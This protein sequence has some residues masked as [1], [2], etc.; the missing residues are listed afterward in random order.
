MK[1]PERKCVTLVLH[2]ISLACLSRAP[3]PVP[4]A[5]RITLEELNNCRVTR[6]H[7]EKWLDQ[8]HL[9]RLLPGLFVR[10]GAQL[11]LD[12]VCM[13]ACVCKRICTCV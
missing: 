7:L 9:E 12:V 11:S 6:I 4:L 3:A 5:E 10:I 8:P 13:H 2:C 1:K